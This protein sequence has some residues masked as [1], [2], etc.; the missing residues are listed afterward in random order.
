MGAQT[1]RSSTRE[2]PFTQALTP[3]ELSALP[4]SQGVALPNTPLNRLKAPPAAAYPLTG[5]AGLAWSCDRNHDT[6]RG[7]GGP[8]SVAARSHDRVSGRRATA[9]NAIIM[10]GSRAALPPD[11]RST[12]AASRVSPSPHSPGIIHRPH[13]QVSDKSC[14]P[15]TRRAA[16]VLEHRSIV[17]TW[18]DREVAHERGNTR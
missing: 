15:R 13:G 5:N 17:V 7:P 6:A 16:R 14:N 4:P 8:C 3:E 9:A 2:T 18:G 11:S 1:A 12:S 10:S